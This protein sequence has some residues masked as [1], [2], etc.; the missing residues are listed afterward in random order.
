MQAANFQDLETRELLPVKPEKLVGAYRKQVGTHIDALGRL[1]GKQQVD[2][3]LLNSAEPL[4]EALY[5]YLVFRQHR[6]GGSDPARMA[7]G[8]SVG[9]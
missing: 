6:R 4:D 8:G 2:Y 5:A 9:G 3:V 1:F 7:L